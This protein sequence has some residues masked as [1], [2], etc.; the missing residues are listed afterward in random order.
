KD[1]RN[2]IRKEVLHL[3]KFV[4]KTV[5]IPVDKNDSEEFNKIFPRMVELLAEE[6]N[7]R[8]LHKSLNRQ[9]FITRMIDLMVSEDY[10]E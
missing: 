2:S 7:V 8:Y 9:E 3:I 4:K 5:A 1:N 10:Y 6:I